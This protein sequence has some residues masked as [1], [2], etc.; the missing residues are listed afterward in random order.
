MKKSLIALV[1]AQALFAGGDIAPVE[2]MTDAPLVVDSTTEYNAALKFGTLGIGVD[3]SHMFNDSFGVRLN[4]NGLKYN[5]SRD[6]ADITYDTDL[7]LFTAGLLAD[8]YPLENN[9]RLS[10]GLY[11]NDNHIDGT[12]KYANGTIEIGDHT[13]N[14]NEI[15]SFNASADYDNN[16]APY[17]GIGWGNKST[18]S[19]WGFTLDVGAL[20]QGS[21]QI[22]AC[23]TNESTLLKD[24]IDSDIEKERKKI[25]DDIKD[26]Q[27]YPVVMI[28][29]NYS[30]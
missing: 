30:F 27:W 20:Y 23:V 13:Y 29:V 19:G 2:P 18:S 9:F 25:E 12:G 4:I 10:A 14:S 11:Y 3:V 28:G 17:V 7:N 5:D 15:G 1:A 6:L 26:Y 21:T 22:H 24:Q 8:Y 16:V